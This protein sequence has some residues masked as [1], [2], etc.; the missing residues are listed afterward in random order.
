M[1][2]HTGNIF[3]LL[4]SEK[5]EDVKRNMNYIRKQRKEQK[6]KPKK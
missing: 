3:F 4:V 5:D 2:Q 6:D 1:R